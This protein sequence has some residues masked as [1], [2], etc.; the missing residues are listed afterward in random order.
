M[1]KPVT[2]PSST[3]VDYQS[4]WYTKDYLE[5]ILDRTSYPRTERVPG[6]GYAIEMRA[7][8][9]RAVIREHHTDLEAQFHD[10]DDCGIDVMVS[11]Q[12]IIGDVAD[13]EPAEAVEVTAL[14][15]EASAAAQQTY[16]GRFFGTAMLPVQDVQ[17]SIDELDRAVD[18]GLGAVCMV[19][20]RAGRPFAD[21]E[22]LPL[23][24]R[25]AAHGLP[26]ILHP[27][28]HSLA[29]AGGIDAGTEIGASLMFD[30]T[31]A[32]LSLV[33]SGTLDVC[34]DLQIVH[35][36]LGGTIP[37]ILGRLDVLVPLWN[38]VP[39]ERSLREYL[40]SNFYADAVNLTP[41]AL[42]LAIECYGADRILFATDYPWMPL[43]IARP[44]VEANASADDAR[45]ILFDNQLPFVRDGLA[46]ATRP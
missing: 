27:A 16:P 14:L 33:T 4:H 36:H 15:N 34:P 12:A 17:A 40:R 25:I 28:N 5:S 21:Q 20:N 13:L 30:T 43:D 7:G 26:I 24:Q 37:F 46:A 42:Q 18:L 3:L 44:Y 19:S 41:G 8:G 11:S 6:G 31:A 10:F 23:F 1:P 38:T 2:S 22:T 9:F 35:P 39:L 29:S 45:A 32:A